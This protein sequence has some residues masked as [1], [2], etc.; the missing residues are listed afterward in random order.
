MA[1]RYKGR[2]AIK[3]IAPMHS[4]IY[5][6]GEIVVNN[7][8]NLGVPSIDA[9]QS[10][11]LLDDNMDYR[12]DRLVFLTDIPSSSADERWVEHVPPDPRSGLTSTKTLHLPFVHQFAVN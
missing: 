3:L 9:S 5:R 10:H 12:C 1:E 4:Q 8:F 2:L 7:G 11:L 6:V